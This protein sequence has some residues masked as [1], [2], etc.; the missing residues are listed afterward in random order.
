MVAIQ[1]CK[2]DEVWWVED[3]KSIL[4]ILKKKLLGFMYYIFVGGSIKSS[5][6]VV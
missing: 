2:D 4:D 6:D 1:I 5:N 3:E